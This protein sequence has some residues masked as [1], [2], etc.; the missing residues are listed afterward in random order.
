MKTSQRVIHLHYAFRSGN[1]HRM[2]AR[3]NDTLRA[4][5]GLLREAALT[6][7]SSRA[8]SNAL[9]RVLFAPAES[10]ALAVVA[11]PRVT[12]IL[13]SRARHR[14][15]LVARKFAASGET[16]YMRVVGHAS[17]PAGS[18]PR[19]IRLRNNFERSEAQATAVARELIRDGVPAQKVLVEAVGDRQTDGSIVARASRSAEIFLQS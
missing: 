8:A 16:G 11:F 17:D 13:D 3:A 4:R 10:P 1:D 19:K 18:L 12:T 6:P 15:R 9:D 14:I 5:H 2:F 7:S